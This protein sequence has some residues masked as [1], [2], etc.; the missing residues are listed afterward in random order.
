MRTRWHRLGPKCMF[1]WQTSHKYSFRAVIYSL[2][3]F[4]SYLWMP[5]KIIWCAW[6]WSI[7]CGGTG[8]R[9]GESQ[10]SV[11]L[12]QNALNAFLFTSRMGKAEVRY[13]LACTNFIARHQRLDEYRLT[14]EQ[15]RNV[16][17]ASVNSGSN[18]MENAFVIQVLAFGFLQHS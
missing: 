12:L 8:A 14:T 10:K 6:N 16:L 1:N 11:L 18:S 3:S 9:D 4:F 5:E 13:C 15:V 2:Y 17:W 7:Q